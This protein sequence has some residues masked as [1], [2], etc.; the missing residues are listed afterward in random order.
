MSGIFGI[1]HLDQSPVEERELHAMRSAMQEWGT[2]A[3]GLWSDGSAGLGSLIAF[4]TPEAI[5]ERSPRRS[6]AGFVLAAEA[7]LDNRPELCGE[8][9]IPP[10][11]LPQLAD[12]ELILRAYERWGERAPDHL[13]GDWSFAA[14]HPSEKRLFLARDHFGNTGLYYHQDARRFAFASSRKALFA[15]GIPRRLNEFYLAC[16][17]VSWSAHSGDQ[18]IELDLHRLPPAHTL[19]LQEGA[20]RVNLYWRLEDTPELRLKSSQD[21]T[22]GLLSIY[23]RAVRDRLRSTGGIGVALSGGLDSGSTAVLAARALR[24]INQHLRAYTA[25]PIHDTAH[26]TGARTIG[27]ELSLAQATTAAAGNVDLIAV[28]AEAVTPIQGIC[29]ALAIHMEPGH[30]ASNAF[31][32]HALLNSA[33]RD[34]LSTLL[35]GQG[36]NATVSWTGLDHGGTVKKLLRAGA[37]KQ[38]AQI[39]LYPYLPLGLV[40]G[41]RHVLH[42]SGLDWSRTAIKQDFARRIDLSSAYVRRSGDASRVEAWYAPLPHRWGIIRPGAS[43]VGSIW[44]ESSAAHGLDVRDATYDKRVMEFALAIPDR[45]YM[46][47]DGMDRWVLREAMRGLLPDSVRLN[48]KLGLQAADVGSRLLDSAAEVDQTLEQLES[49]LFVQQYLDTARMRRVWQ[50]LQQQVGPQ[51]THATVTI[52]MRGMMAGL[53]LLDRERGG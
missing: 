20:H 37:W 4:E 12:G 15:L 35:T 42:R 44:S 24:E 6:S 45:E 10:N 7:R 50:A 46:S 8:L 36:G 40:R 14:W 22:E 23:D 48:R 1:V 29:S 27:D 47:P 13:L 25:V 3:G 52:L 5:H 41:L 19:T 2:D 18:T 21:Y 33:R 11:E 51:T 49:S 26:S 34:G 28:K 38:A 31:W 39:L 32:V 9:G 30:A 43:P 17:L 53:H 16:V